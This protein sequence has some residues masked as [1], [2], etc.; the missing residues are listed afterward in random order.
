VNALLAV[1]VHVKMLGFFFLICEH[2]TVFSVAAQWIEH[3]S[4]VTE[5]EYLTRQGLECAV[6]Q[7]VGAKVGTHL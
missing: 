5:Q 2:R 3:G 6:W 4:S 7:C 1:L